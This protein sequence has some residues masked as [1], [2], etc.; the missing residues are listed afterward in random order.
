MA[1]R[2]RLTRRTF[3]KVS[4]T[5]G[6]GLLIGSYLAGCATE[7]PAPVAVATVLPAPTTPPTTPPTA[8]PALPTV[9][10]TSPPT[11]IPVA[12]GPLQPNLFVRIDPDGAVTL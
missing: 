7:A 6:G 5:A 9:A 4:F 11:A 12:T 2:T 1:L 3:L 8:I 10:P